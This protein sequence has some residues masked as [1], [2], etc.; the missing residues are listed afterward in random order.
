MSH[1]ASVEVTGPSPRTRGAGGG[2]WCAGP[3]GGSIPTRARNS[4]PRAGTSRPARVHPHVRG[5]QDDYSGYGDRE[6]GPSPRARGAAGCRTAGGRNVG[7]IPAGA[8]NRGIA[9]SAPTTPMVHPRGRGEQHWLLDTGHVLLGPSPRA[10]GTAALDLDGGH[11]AGVHPRGRGEQSSES[12]STVSSPGPSRGRGEQRSAHLPRVIDEGPSPRARGTAGVLTGIGERDGSIPAGAGNSPRTRA[13]CRAPR[14]HPRGRGEQRV[15][16]VRPSGFAGSIPAG[17]GNSLPDLGIHP[18]GKPFW[19]TNKAS[20]TPTIQPHKTPNTPYHAHPHMPLTREER[21]LHTPVTPPPQA[22]D[23][24]APDP[25]PQPQQ[26]GGAIPTCAESRCGSSTS[27]PSAEVHPRAHG[28]QYVPLHHAMQIPGSSSRARE[29]ARADPV[30]RPSR[31][32]HPRVYG[33]Q[34]VVEPV[35]HDLIQ[36]IQKPALDQVRN[37]R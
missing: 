7:S 9:I 27:D 6:Q 33:K 15:A 20:D 4:A 13:R 1:P 26:P 5:E 19:A 32:A 29:A 24:A 17:A 14:V 35:E 16:G 37:R 21:S 10:R 23:I 11:R 28:E 2:R 25:L 8:G 34:R 31:E 3:R 12:V 18:P 22:R 36:L 30:M